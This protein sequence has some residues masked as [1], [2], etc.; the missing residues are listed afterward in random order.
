VTLKYA[1]FKIIVLSSLL[2]HFFKGNSF[3]ISFVF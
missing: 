1:C 3:V 2:T